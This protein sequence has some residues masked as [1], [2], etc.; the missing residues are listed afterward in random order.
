MTEQQPITKVSAKLGVKLN[1]G[2]FNSAELTLW[3]EDR[4]RPADGSTDAAL[5][6]LV[7]RLDQ[8]LE[9]WAKG[10]KNDSGS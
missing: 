6:R 10:F 1:L 7:E 2:D 8:K 3:I 5:D 9:K 4:V